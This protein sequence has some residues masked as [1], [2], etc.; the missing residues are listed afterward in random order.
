MLSRNIAASVAF[1]ACCSAAVVSAEPSR[2]DIQKAE[3]HFRK[4]AEWYAQGDYA[5]AIVEFKFG[6]NLA[7]N[8][9]FLYNMSLAYERL[10][11]FDEAIEVAQE[12]RKMGGMPEEIALRNESRIAGFFVIETARD[13]AGDVGAAIAARE[14]D[15]DREQ[16]TVVAPVTVEQPDG[17]AAL[18]WV[19]VSVAAVGGGFALG[20]LLTN[21]AVNADI[22]ALQTAASTRD[23]E[24][25]DRLQEEIPEK[26]AR[27]KLLY[28]VGGVAAGIG[29]ALFVT[30]LL[31]GTETVEVQT[32]AG[33]GGGGPTF[34]ATLRF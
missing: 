10:G 29:V 16:D 6:N 17:L 34:A 24:N 27:G 8:A 18:G 25:Y 11:S 20:G 23:V 3:D 32:T 31:V 13:V 12:A 19:G 14:K 15:A 26:Q 22:E 5:K 21:S 9:M 33:F 30:D 4:G 7:P 2:A 28:T 1:L